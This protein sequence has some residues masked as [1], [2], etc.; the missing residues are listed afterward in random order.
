MIRMVISLEDQEK[1]WLDKMAKAKHVS[2]AKIHHL[3]LVTRNTKDFHPKTM[4]FVIIP[5][6]AKLPPS[7]S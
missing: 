2:I 4:N 3:K 7:A 1:K 5:D 6:Y